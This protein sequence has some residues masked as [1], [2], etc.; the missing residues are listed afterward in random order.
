MEDDAPTRDLLCAALRDEGYVVDAAADGVDGLAYLR[1]W[2]YRVLLLD[3]LMP[4]MDGLRVLRALHEEPSVRPSVVVVLS[5]L[6]QPT[7]V[8]AALDAGADDYV[9]K[10]VA[11]SDLIVRLRLWLRRV[12]AHAESALP[13][14]V[15]VMT[16]EGPVVHASDRWPGAGVQETLS[17]WL[18][19]GFR[20]AIGS[21]ILRESAWPV[22][23]ATSLLKL[24]ALTPDHR[25]HRE[26]VMDLLWP[27]LEPQAAANNYHKVLHL[28][29]R[30][31]EVA[32]GDASSYLQVHDGIVT[33]DPPGPLWIDVEAFQAAAQTA[34]RDQDPASYE[35]ALR[36]YTGGLLPDDRYEDW[37]VGRCEELATLHGEL[38]VE[39][40][41][42][43]EQR[44]EVGAAIAA[45]RQV[46]ACDPAHEEAQA[47]FMRLLAQ[48]GQRH[49]ALRQYQQVRD[50]LQRELDAEPSPRL[51]AL[52][53]HLRHGHLAPPL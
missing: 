15:G 52:Y 34:R 16:G 23:K 31:L 32:V 21:H 4:R 12:T 35:D 41:D 13:G 51:Q 11:L 42:L 8:L 40:A 29:R 47:R 37:V 3:L 45:L 39:L 44:G 5:A 49:L 26:Q 22:R 7:D 48:T 20:V 10:P 17:I 6:N 27:D 28:V 46:V 33:L 2:R 50:T 25:L 53:Q 18:L 24:L 9:A 1:R 14:A 43:H 38:L 19:G 36:L 30:T